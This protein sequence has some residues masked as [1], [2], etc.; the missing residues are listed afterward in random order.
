VSLAER[1]WDPRYLAAWRGR[2]DALAARARD[3]AERARRIERLALVAEHGGAWVEALDLARTPLVLDLS[4]EIPQPRAPRHPP[5]RQTRPRR[6]SL[7]ASAGPRLRR[8]R[9]TRRAPSPSYDRSRPRGFVAS[10]RPEGGYSVTDRFGVPVSGLVLTAAGNAV[11]FVPAGEPGDV[12][13][14]HQTC[15]CQHPATQH[16]GADLRGPCQ[17]CSCT[18]FTLDEL[19]DGLSSDS[20][21][22]F[23][24]TVVAFARELARR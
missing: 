23:G 17:I 15:T 16:F 4:A 7:R 9:Q 14:A 24:Q 20:V 12:V 2:I 6:G 3:P 22:R 8:I 10:I 21:I 1:G 13:E 18:K 19:P 11:E 5:A